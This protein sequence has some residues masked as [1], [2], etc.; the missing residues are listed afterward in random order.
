MFERINKID[1]CLARLTSKKEKRHRLPIS[2]IREKEE[3][4]IVNKRMIGNIT[5]NF[6]II[7][8]TT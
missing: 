8:L 5:N 2:G 3:I 7:H 6:M 4:A 1:T